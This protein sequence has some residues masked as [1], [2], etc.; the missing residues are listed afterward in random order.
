MWP[1]VAHTQ[2]RGARYGTT[3]ITGKKFG[4]SHPAAELETFLGSRQVRNRYGNCSEMWL[5]RRQRDDS[6]FPKPI[7]VSGR[8]LWRLSDLVAW[9]LKCAVDAA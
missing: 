1:I 3:R 4:T 5:Y 9:E 2:Q 8:K 7:E 6:G